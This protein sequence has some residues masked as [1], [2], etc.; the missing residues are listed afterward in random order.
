[1]HE[2]GEEI[3]ARECT[4]WSEECH[5]VTIKLNNMRAER[6]TLRTRVKELEGALEMLYEEQG[7][8]DTDAYWCAMHKAKQALKDGG[9]K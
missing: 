1:M 9:A 3:R 7:D 2:T 8:T 5:K 4:Y 6:D